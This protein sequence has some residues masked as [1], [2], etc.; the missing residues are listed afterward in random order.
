M[1]NPRQM[2]L[3]LEPRTLADLVDYR[4]EL[5][6]LRAD[7]NRLDRENMRLRDV[8]RN[9]VDILSHRQAYAQQERQMRHSYPVPE[10]N[11]TRDII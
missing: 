7:I 4:E 1:S 11:Y 6:S 2:E 3:E 8:L 9:V 5:E 10:L